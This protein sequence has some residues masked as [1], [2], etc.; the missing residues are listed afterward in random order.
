MSEQEIRVLCDKVKYDVFER[1]LTV[2][3]LQAPMSVVGDLHGQLPCLLEL[4]RVAGTLQNS[5]T[6]YLFLG[7]YVDRGPY[8]IELVCLLCLLKLK[9]P[10]RIFLLRGNH[11]SRQ[12]ST[13]YGMHAESVKKTG[14]SNVWKFLTDMFDFLPLAAIVHSAGGSI[15]GIHGGLGPSMHSLDQV[16]IIDRF[17]EIDAEGVMSDLLWSDPDEQVVGFSVSPR[18]AGF[19][20]GHDVVRKFIHVNNLVHIVRAHQ[21][22]MSGF[23]I[24]F[25]D[26]TVSTVWSA[27]NY[28]YRFGNLASVMEIDEFGRRSFNVFEQSA[29]DPFLQA[30]TKLVAAK[31]NYF[32]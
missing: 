24:L 4:F 17:R 18:G 23:Q 29:D 2:L 20:F 32:L 26:Q 19:V 15:L 27:P 16:R 8:S 1:E 31:P 22:C 7:D 6:K 3:E 25:P 14:S 12:T 28:C 30:R 21:L 5:C 13:V 11:E 10:D 9:F